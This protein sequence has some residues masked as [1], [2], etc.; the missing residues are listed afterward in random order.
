MSSNGA[1][2][3]RLLRATGFG[4]R[5]LARLVSVRERVAAGRRPGA[6]VFA[7]LLAVLPH[8]SLGDA[9]IPWSLL[10]DLGL[11][12][13]GVFAAGVIASLASVRAAL[14]SPLLQ[15]LRKE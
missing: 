13:A 14:R 15:A 7:A 12:L 8:K 11:M 2:S 1:V 9:S 3:W 4:R 10:R 5:R 6:G